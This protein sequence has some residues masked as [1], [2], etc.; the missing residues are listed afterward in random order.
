M[1]ARISLSI[2]A[3][4]ALLDITLTLATTTKSRT[5]PFYFPSVGGLLP[6]KRKF[7]LISRGERLPSK[8]WDSLLLTSQGK[9]CRSPL[10][11]FRGGRVGEK[12]LLG[13]GLTQNGHI[14]A[15]RFSDIHLVSSQVTTQEGV[16]WP[17]AGTVTC[18]DW[19]Y[20]YCLWY[21]IFWGVH[22]ISTWYDVQSHF[23]K[24]P[25][26]PNH[27]EATCLRLCITTS[28][29]DQHGQE[30]SEPRI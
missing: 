14:V 19:P 2:R 20:A 18:L 6:S 12:R 27:D 10:A 23:F 25:T 1:V 8:M 15:K 24:I 13:T 28:R 7:P 4:R 9:G 26:Y 22:L 11:T 17:A 30:S 16:F 3:A 21:N 29:R 5:A